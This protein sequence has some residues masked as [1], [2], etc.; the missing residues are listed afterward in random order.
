VYEFDPGAASV[1]RIATLPSAV[2][3]AAAAALGN[4]VYVLGGRGS[5]LGTQTRRITSIDLRTGRV[6][7]AGGL[8]RALSDAGAAAVGSA[9]VVAGGRD[10]SGSV[11]SEV[12][13]LEP[14]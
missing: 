8:P 7:T 5:V 10:S 11:R 3:H 6:R 2:T 13:R 14:R 4:A 1:R 9:I 12:L